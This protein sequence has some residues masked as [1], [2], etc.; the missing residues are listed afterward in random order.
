M[1]KKTNYIEVPLQDD[2]QR[3]DNFLS[4]QLKGVP[5]SRIYSMVRKG[6]VRVNGKRASPKQKLSAKDRLRL[7]PVNTKQKRQVR[8]PDEFLNR[9]AKSILYI[10][11]AIIVINKPAGMAV[12]QGSGLHYGIVDGLQ[13]LDS[14]Y[15]SVSLVHRLDK[16]TS[17]CLLLA[18]TRDMLRSLQNQM[19][20]R[21]F[22]K[23]YR[24]LIKGKL[25]HN[26]EVTAPLAKDE[27]GGQRLMKADPQGQHAK[28]VFK[29][30]RWFNGQT[31]VE[32][33]LVTGRMHQIRVH[34]SFSGHP[35]GG[36]LKYGDRQF[37]QYLKS[38]G[39]NRLFLHAQ[40][41][42]FHH[43][44]TG[45]WVEFVAPMDNTLLSLLRRLK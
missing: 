33:E 7:P 17:G 30:A 10:D 5:K 16:E 44:S 3:L 34:A 20:E 23:H 18:R 9:L 31:F 36:D 26:R 2:G 35:V 41:L 45:K 32:V 1:H 27:R 28:T 38:L 24:A 37:N 25:Q 29:P 43:P 39:L 4:R 13:W 21:K 12:H 22:E 42:G 19:R 14:A 11:D 40:Y 8:P 6:E 15:H